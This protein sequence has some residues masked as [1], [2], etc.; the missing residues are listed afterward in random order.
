MDSITRNR[1]K[2]NQ[3]V[4]PLHFH[5]DR[6]RRSSRVP[7]LHALLASSTGSRTTM[8]TRLRPTPDLGNNKHNYRPAASSVSSSNHH[9]LKYECQAKDPAGTVIR[10]LSSP[11]GHSNLQTSQYHQ[12]PWK[13]AIPLAPRFRRDPLRHSC[14]QRSR[15]GLL[16]SGSWCQESAVEIWVYD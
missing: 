4:L 7:A 15:A 14:C 8:P 3:M 6:H 2:R 5:W 12:S 16:R 13:P 10:R 9:P 11:S 1:S